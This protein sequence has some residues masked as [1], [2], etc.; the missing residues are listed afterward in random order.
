VFT[1][2]QNDYELLRFRASFDNDGAKQRGWDQ[3]LNLDVEWRG[4][5][6]AFRDYRSAQKQK[7]QE[8]L[9]T[10]RIYYAGELMVEG[11]NE[12]EIAE[13]IKSAFGKTGTIIEEE[14]DGFRASRPNFPW[15][16]LP[17]LFGQRNSLE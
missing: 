4:E 14:V 15:P 1:V 3:K 16:H 6:M 5:A 8:M 11:L 12:P 2:R 10:M 17:Q 13:R 7:A 9:S